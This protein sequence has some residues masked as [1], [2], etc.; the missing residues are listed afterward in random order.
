MGFV[1]HDPKE[2]IWQSDISFALHASDDFLVVN[3]AREIENPK[4]KIWLKYDDFVPIDAED[5]LTVAEIAK[6]RFEREQKTLIHCIA[7][8]HRSVTFALAS[9]MYVYNVKIKEAM[10]MLCPP[11]IDFNTYVHEIPYHFLSLE[12]F[13][14]RYMR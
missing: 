10:K 4:A 14:T 5:L 12:E 11:C 9:L 2:L 8:V 3:V 1:R 7:G 13:Y 6:S